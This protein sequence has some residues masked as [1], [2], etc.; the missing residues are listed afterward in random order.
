MLDLLLILAYFAI[1]L[2]IGLASRTR[3]DATAEEFFVSGRSL[4]WPSIALSTIATNI[5]AGHFLGVAGSAYLY[6]LAQANLE[7]NAVFGLL[8]AA[9]VFVPLYLQRRVVTISQFFE[10]RFGPRVATV[11]SVLTMVLYG[12]L[13]LG[14]ALFWGAYAADALFPAQTALIHAEPT[15][16]IMVMMVGLGVF[17][18]FYTALGGLTAVVRTD[19][20]QF[21]LLLGGGLVLTVLA[22]DRAGGWGALQQ[23]GLMHLHLPADHPKLPWTAIGAMLLLNLNYWGANQVILQRALAARSVRDAQLGLL[24]GGV[25]KYLTAVITT[26]PAVALAVI[27]R[28]RPLGDPD[29]AYPTL[30]DLLLPVGLRGLVLCGLFASLMSTVDSIFNSVSTLWSVDIYK[31]RLAPDATDAQ[32]IAMARRAI[33]VTLLAGL[34]FG[35]FQVHVKFSNPEFALTHWFNDMSYSIKVGFVVLV[36]SAVF[37]VG[38][39]PNLVLAMML[40]TVGLKL[41]LER[42]LPGVAYFNITALTILVGFAVVAGE[43]WARTRRAVAWRGLW[44]AA[45]RTAARAGLAL[46]AS[47]VAVQVLFH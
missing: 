30:V 25:L 8:L 12:F 21:T 36:S 42:L 11:Y 1:I 40:A 39:R 31:R 7:I 43:S 5:H 37:L 14:T 38:A 17:S 3:R 27:L 41:G 28:D 46:A 6:G 9:F 33:A 22:V 13:Y 20:F 15:V 45:D 23:S 18:A 32:V 4:R 19:V 44:H 2:A 29:L 24:A 10:E 47:L 34:A 26:I 16:R 35:F